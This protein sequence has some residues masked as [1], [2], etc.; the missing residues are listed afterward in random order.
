MLETIWFIL[1]SLLWAVF[2]MLDGFDLGLGTL[3]PFFAKNEG[4]RRLLY[5]AAGPFWD[6]NEVWLISAGGVTFAAFPKTYAVLFSALYVPLLLLL[7]M[8]IFR[9]ISYEFRSKIAHSL[10][11]GLWDAVHFAANAAA[12]ILLGIIFG[13]LFMGIPIDAEGVFHGDV[14]TFLNPYA[15]AG[16]VFF[17][18]VFALHG[19][20][21]LCFKTEGRLQE[22]ALSFALLLWQLAAVL[23][24][25]FLLLTAFSTDLFAAYAAAPALLLIPLAAV[26]GLAGIKVMLRK[27]SILL[28]WA[29]SCLFILGVTFF[30]TMG[31]FPR[32]LIST[33]DPNATL[34]AFNSA[35]SQLTLSIMLGVALVMV[36][37]VLIYQSWAYRL[38]SHKLHAKDV[39]ADPHAY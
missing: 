34:T 1:W 17:L 18:I 3:L 28:A 37:I 24:V 14:V 29:S 31:M 35:S 25:A 19:S 11:R 12:A 20:L 6:G 4:E 2:F 32:M 8:L 33:L 23:L 5:N 26:A 13:N 9:A 22:R 15:L 38:F 27:G 36:P 39:L 10:W 7:F 30:G 16:G 21:W